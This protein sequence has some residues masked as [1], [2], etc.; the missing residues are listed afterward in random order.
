MAGARRLE[1]AAARLAVAQAGAAMA[2]PATATALEE[3]PLVA[4]EALEPDPATARA[5]AGPGAPM[6]SH[7]AMLLPAASPALLAWTRYCSD[8]W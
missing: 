7:S 2:P 8:P 6:G 4:K 1:Q 3:R 5:T